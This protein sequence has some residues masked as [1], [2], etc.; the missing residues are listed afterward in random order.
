MGLRYVSFLWPVQSDA[1]VCQGSDDDL[2][3]GANIRVSV[4][5]EHTIRKTGRIMMP[6]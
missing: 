4:G 3:D 1:S 2:T 6:L 5:G